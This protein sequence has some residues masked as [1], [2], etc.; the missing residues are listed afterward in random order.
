LW[1]RHIDDGAGHAADE[2]HAPWGLAFH[3]VL[4]DGDGEQ[5]CAVDVDAPELAD[6]VNRVIDGL[7]ILGEAGGGDEVVDPAVL[8][9]DFGDGG[10][11]GFLG[12]D[13]GVVG[14]YFGDSGGGLVLGLD[15][16]VVGGTY[17]SAPGFSFLKFATSSS[18]CLAASSSVEY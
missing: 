8:Y 15:W 14:C 1:L 18:A 6:A 12:G 9:D 17:W 13:V 16:K 4:R 11:D 10:F 3:Q 5:V 7:E 2:D